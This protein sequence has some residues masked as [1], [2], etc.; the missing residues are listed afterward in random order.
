MRTGKHVQWGG[1]ARSHC[2]AQVL[3]VRMETNYLLGIFSLNPVTQTLHVINSIAYVTH[4]T[5][6]Q[7]VYS[8]MMPLLPG[9][10]AWRKGAGAQR[11]FELWCGYAHSTSDACH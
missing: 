2:V 11:V 6:Q 10:T 4:A 8:G 9:P 1:A 7:A 5:L 3:G